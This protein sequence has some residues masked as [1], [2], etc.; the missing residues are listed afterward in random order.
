M[1]HVGRRDDGTW[2]VRIGSRVHN[3]EVSL[4]DDEAEKLLAAERNL[5]PAEADQATLGSA[6]LS[7]LVRF[8]SSQGRL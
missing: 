2:V 8:A 3:V 1:A 5:V 7:A 6:V 4:S